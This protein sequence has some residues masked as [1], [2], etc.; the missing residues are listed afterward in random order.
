[1][2]VDM[3]LHDGLIE[4]EAFRQYVKER[5]GVGGVVRARRVMDL[6]EP[7]AESPM[8]SR[9]RFLLVQS[10]LPRPEAQ[11]ELHDAR[12]V[13]VGRPDLF[14][15]EARLGL[16][17]D[18]ENH[19][20]RMISDNRRQNALQGV[21]VTLLRYTFSDLRERPEAVVNE[22]RRALA[23]GPTPSEHEVSLSR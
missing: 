23:G 22:V 9:L 11:V 20:D 6:A 2:A 13:F 8:E 19:R 16:E 10:G 7:K 1:M 14:Y 21:G 5:N 12:G 15:R 17:Y 18:G 3:A 4:I